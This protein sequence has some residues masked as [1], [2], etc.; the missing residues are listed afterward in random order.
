MAFG[1]VHTFMLKSGGGGG[2]GATDLFSVTPCAGGSNVLCEDTLGYM[3]AVDDVVVYGDG[4]TDYCGTIASTGQSGTAAYDI[5][6]TG[7]SNCSECES[8]IGGP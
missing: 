6:G 2:G 4:S 8:S 1:G 7:F 3:P 5:S